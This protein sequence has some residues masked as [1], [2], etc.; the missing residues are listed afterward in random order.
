MAHAGLGYRLF[1][2]VLLAVCAAGL[3]QGSCNVLR[4][5]ARAPAALALRA[6]GDAGGVWSVVLQG[7][8]LRRYSDQLFLRGAG[9]DDEEEAA[10]DEDKEEAEEGDAGK[11]EEEDPDAGPMTITKAIRQV[12]CQ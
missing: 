7:S 8:A 4:G 1:V 10:D 12:R 5:A 11:A 3:A 2:A 6:R 9:D